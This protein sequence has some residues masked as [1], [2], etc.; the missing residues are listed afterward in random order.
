MRAVVTQVCGVC[1][2]PTTSKAAMDDHI[3][4][5]H[6]VNWAPAMMERAEDQREFRP[7]AAQSRWGSD[8]R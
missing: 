5:F 7:C 2:F 1:R 8:L 3:K 4:E 6:G